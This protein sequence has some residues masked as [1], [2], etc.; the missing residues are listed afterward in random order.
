MIHL[1][2]KQRVRGFASL[3]DTQDHEWLA[4]CKYDDCDLTRV[5]CPVCGRHG[6]V[7]THKSG[8]KNP[9]LNPS[10][11]VVIAHGHF[12]GRPHKGRNISCKI[13]G[14]ILLPD[15]IIWTWRIKPDLKAKIVREYN[16]FLG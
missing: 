11:D 4:R 8:D 1:A 14:R 16:D 12:L 5:K 6:H 10:V 13:D 15:D 7:T 9:N 2:T 3:Y